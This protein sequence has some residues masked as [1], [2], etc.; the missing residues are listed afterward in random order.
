MSEQKLQKSE[1]S[2]KIEEV[3]VKI[4]TEPDFINSPKHN[5]SLREARMECSSFSDKAICKMLL[6]SQSELDS[7]YEQALNA[8]RKALS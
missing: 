3:K 1:E 2:I 4:A 5:D 8:L 6:I 7:T